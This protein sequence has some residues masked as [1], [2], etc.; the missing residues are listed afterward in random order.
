MAVPGK[1]E[2]PAESGGARQA[3]L[4]RPLRG[5]GQSRPLSRTFH[6]TPSPSPGTHGS[7]PVLDQDQHK[8]LLTPSRSAANRDSRHEWR[9]FRLSARAGRGGAPEP[10]WLLQAAE[11]SFDLAWV[12]MGQVRLDQARGGR[13][14]PG[15]ASQ[16]CADCC[17]VKDEDTPRAPESCLL[18]AS[19]LG[20]GALTVIFPVLIFLPIYKVDPS[21]PIQFLQILFFSSN[22]YFS[23][24]CVPGILHFWGRRPSCLMCPVVATVFSGWNFVELIVMFKPSFR[25]TFLSRVV[26]VNYQLCF[27]HLLYNFCQVNVSSV[28]NIK[29]I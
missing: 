24:L 11:V 22:I 27:M 13:G 14:W 10:L 1:H 15:A 18:P 3:S 5:P 26:H 12:R 28:Q 20:P 23:I 4:R 21:P 16:S 17:I 8:A 9:H 7:W 25:N 19:T 6:Q 29:F 2:A